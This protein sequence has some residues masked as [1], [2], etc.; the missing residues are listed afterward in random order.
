ML[1]IRPVKLND[2]ELKTITELSIELGY[3]ADVSSTLSRLQQILSHDEHLV[4]VAEYDAE[5][6]GWI[7]ACYC[8]RVESDA[9]VEICGLVV[10]SKS[11]GL[12]IAK[13]LIEVC[14]S[15][16]SKF[17]VSK[18]RVRSNVQRIEAHAFYPK[19]GFKASKDSRVYDL[20]I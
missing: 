17:K 7:H 1:Q 13:Q 12:G 10:S 8:M 14:K 3:Q 18:L 6:V 5:V 2:E 19:L 16:A 15:W 9:F 20:P 4:L 11:R